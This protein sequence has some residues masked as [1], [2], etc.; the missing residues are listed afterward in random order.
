[1]GQCLYDRRELAVIVPVPEAVLADSSFDI[2][3]EV[4]PR[5]REAMG[6]KI[7]N[8]ILFGGE[9]P[10]EW[11]TDV[12]TLAAKNK[13][14]GPI[15]YA[16]LLGKDGLF[17]K[18]ELAA[19]CGCR[20][21]RSDRKGRTARPCWIPRAVLCSVPICRVQP[22]TRWTVPRCTSRRT[23]ALMLLRPS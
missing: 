16:K 2:M 4:Q 22:P 6:A 21:R 23:A 18:V 5:V 17:S 12:L 13:V 3:G 11:T 9:R 19:W 1:M 7:D 15:D 20:G 14:T 10:T 8:A